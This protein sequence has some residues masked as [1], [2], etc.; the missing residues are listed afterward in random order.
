MQTI[1]LKRV[2]LLETSLKEEEPFRSIWDFSC[3]LIKKMMTNLAYQFCK[4]MKKNFFL[5]SFLF[6]LIMILWVSSCSDL[7]KESSNSACNTALDNQDFDTAIKV[8]TSSKGKGDAY[9]GKGGFTVTNLLNNSGG[10]PIPS[11]I[12]SAS[13]LGATNTSYDWLLVLFRTGY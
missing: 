3:G 8:C 13:G 6:F 1:R 11:H 2:I 10:E 9:M 12:S 7:Q 4:F 5:I